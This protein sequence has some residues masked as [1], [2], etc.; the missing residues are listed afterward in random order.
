MWMFHI[1]PTERIQKIFA[2]AIKQNTGFFYYEIQV[3]VAAEFLFVLSENKLFLDLTY[4]VSKVKV[5][6]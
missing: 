3:V 2:T 4:L 6:K 5:K 1:Y